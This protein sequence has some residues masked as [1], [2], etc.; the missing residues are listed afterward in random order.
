MSV[1]VYDES[2]KV[3]PINLGGRC[4]NM[5]PIVPD[6]IKRLNPGEKVDFYVGWPFSGTG[7]E[8]PGKYNLVLFYDLRAPNTEAWSIAGRF[9]GGKTNPKITKR[10]KRIPKLLIKSKPLNIEIHSVTKNM[11]EG[12]VVEY[13]HER[14][15]PMFDF[16]AKDLNSRKWRVCDIR[17]SN[18]WISCLVKFVDGY[19][20]PPRPKYV[21][22][23][24]W[25]EQ[26]RYL[27]EPS[28]KSPNLRVHALP[29]MLRFSQQNMNG[30]K[31]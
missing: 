25:F 23:G 6:D 24:Y 28:H 1:E 9:S 18:G 14:E 22:K 17:Q 20:P 8:K 27:F 31:A 21:T 7:F 13:Y 16:V 15:R 4:G 2:A 11:L 3:I 26:G 10:I 5:N 29:K 30:Y 19:M 12:M